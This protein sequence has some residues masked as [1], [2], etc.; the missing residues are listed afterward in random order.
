MKNR[1]EYI[2]FISFSYFFRFIGL[3]LSRKFANPIAFIFYYFIPI[4][5]QTVIK[6][7]SIAFPDLNEEGKKKIAYESYRSFAISL[8]EILYMPWI[9]KSLM[10]NIVAIQNASIISERYKENKGLILL[11]AHYANWEY[12]AASV[13]LQLGQSLAI[14]VK[15]Q[16]NNLV[17]DWMNKMRTRWGNKIVPLGL[18]IRNIYSTLKN[19]EIVAMVADQRGPED[20]LKLEFF[21]KLTSV[22]VGPAV[23]SLK[24]GAPII[25]CIP[26]RQ[27]DYSYKAETFEVDQQDLT[28]SYEERIKQLTEKLLRYLEQ[29]ITE[30]PEQWLW[31]HDRW[32]H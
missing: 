26:V 19:K 27:N 23:L 7:L 6:N 25:Y 18:S 24:T 31:M 4:R 1:I 3:R 17:N 29:V 2:L 5:K 30:H 11:A 9:K 8:V 21:G 10:K 16:R 20:S 14:I 32:K 13:G 28:G 22:F 15:G 12:I